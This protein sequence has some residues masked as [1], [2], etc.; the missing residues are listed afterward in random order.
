MDLNNLA[1]LYDTQKKYDA[2]EQLYKRALAIWEKSLGSDHPH[3]ASGLES[4]ATL[5]RSTKR[6][7][8][9]IKLEARASA[10]RAKYRSQGNANK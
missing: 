4:Y 5:L 6:Q 7:N 10:I 8:E 2:A 1:I 3:V 9:A